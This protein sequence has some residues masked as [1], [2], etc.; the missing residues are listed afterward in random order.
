MCY[1]I[2]SCLYN[3]PAL[4]RAHMR[5]GDKARV[6]KLNGCLR[7]QDERGDV[8]KVI[9][10]EPWIIKVLEEPRSTGFRRQTPGSRFKDPS[11]QTQFQ[12]HLEL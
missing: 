7:S 2:L 5:R 12:F 4:T 6:T 11:A 1:T 9:V 8:S 3:L 10:T